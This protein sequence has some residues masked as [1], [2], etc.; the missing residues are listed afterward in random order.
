MSVFLLFEYW[1][2][3]DNAPRDGDKQV[4]GGDNA[5]QDGDKQ[6]QG[7]DNAPEGSNKLCY[8]HNLNMLQ[9]Y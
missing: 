5:P 6:G 3:G 1:H 7:G 9:F 8:E 4:C 2:G